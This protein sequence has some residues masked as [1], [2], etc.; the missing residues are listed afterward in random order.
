VFNLETRAFHV[1]AGDGDAPSWSPDGR[2]IVFCYGDYMKEIR[3]DGTGMRPILY[4]T[5]KKGE[6]FA[7][8]WGA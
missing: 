4:V 5:S 8:D 6:N 7:P 3:S 1:L 2:W